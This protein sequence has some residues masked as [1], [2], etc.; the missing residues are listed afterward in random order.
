MPVDD[1]G[2]E[3]SPRCPAHAEEPHP[4]PCGPCSDARALHDDWTLQHRLWTAEQAQAE[5]EAFEAAQRAGIDA[6]ALCDD[7]GYH[8]GLPCHHDPDAPTRAE[9][10]LAACRDALG[11]YTE[12]P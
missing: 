1:P 6:C 12:Q 11:M 7:D 5:R 9:R 8:G 3:P 2:P 4:W 10:G